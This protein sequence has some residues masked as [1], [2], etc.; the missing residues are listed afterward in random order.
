MYRDP[1]RSIPAMVPK[2]ATQLFALLN[3]PLVLGF[4][5]TRLHANVNVLLGKQVRALCDDRVAA[6]VV[7][8]DDAG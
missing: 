6:M 5:M 1:S 7:R 3:L 8:V 2:P 4:S